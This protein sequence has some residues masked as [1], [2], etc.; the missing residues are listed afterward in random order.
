MEEER[1][2]WREGCGYDG[3]LISFQ[4]QEKK[5][6]NARTDGDGWMNE[7]MGRWVDGWLDG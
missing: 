5:K 2:E 3:A 6:K 4:K 1:K 7:W